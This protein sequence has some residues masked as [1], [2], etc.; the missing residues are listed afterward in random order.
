MNEKGCSRRQ[1]DKIRLMPFGEYV[2]LPRWVPGADVLG[3]VV[4]DFTPASAIR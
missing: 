2:P 1:Y 3:G 4:G